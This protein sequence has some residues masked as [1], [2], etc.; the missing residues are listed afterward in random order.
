[1]FKVSYILRYSNTVVVA[2]V[3]DTLVKVLPFF[4][5]SFFLAE[6]NI[7]HH[8]HHHHQDFYVA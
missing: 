7:H 5:Q 6:K 4:S 8:H 2:T 3:N 1:M